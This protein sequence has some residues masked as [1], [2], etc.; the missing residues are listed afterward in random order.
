MG[1]TYQEDEPDS[2]AALLHNP[3][4]NGV[5]YTLVPALIA[6]NTPQQITWYLDGAQRAGAT[7]EGVQA[8][9]VITHRSCKTVGICHVR[10]KTE[11]QKFQ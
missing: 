10:V 3:G 8:V 11:A 5:V 4:L 7:L 9:K 2:P 1:L 6:D